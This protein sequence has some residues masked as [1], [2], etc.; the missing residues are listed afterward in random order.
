VVVVLGHCPAG[1]EL[2]RSALVFAVSLLVFA[3]TLVLKLA[4][5][6]VFPIG[7]ILGH[8]VVGRVARLAVEARMDIDA[9]IMANTDVGE[10]LWELWPGFDQIFGALV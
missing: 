8:A 2:H 4:P 9:Q 1:S 10:V 6:D 5:V 7:G 3:Q